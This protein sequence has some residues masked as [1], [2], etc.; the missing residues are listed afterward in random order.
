MRPPARAL[1]VLLLLALLL[2][3]PV[4]PP[5]AASHPGEAQL[6][7]E[8][9]LP[10]GDLVEAA[11]ALDR[12]DEAGASD[13]VEAA[14]TAW[15]DRFR[16]HSAEGVPTG[17]ADAA[18]DAMADES[19]PV[20]F[21]TLLVRFE[22][23]LFEVAV[24][25]VE[26]A[27]E[28]GEADGDGGG[29]VDHAAAHAW[30]LAARRLVDQPGRMLPFDAPLS[31][32]AAERDPSPTAVAAA[33]DAAAA[34]RLLE[35]V[36]A[37]DDLHALGEDPAWSLHVDRGRPWWNA[38]RPRAE[39]VLPPAAFGALDRNMS[40]LEAVIEA[41]SRDAPPPL[42]GVRG[43]LTS[44][45]YHRS[46]ERLDE[47][48]AGVEAGL[49]GLHRALHRDP[50]RADARW[51]AF[52]A[53]YARHRS[54]LVLVGEGQAPTLDAAVLDVNASRPDGTSA[55]DDAVAHAARTLRDAALLEYGLVLKVEV[56]AV[57]TDRVH[58]YQVTLLRPPLE[59]LRSYAVDLA[60]DPAVV[61]VRDVEPL[62]FDANFSAVIDADVG[63]AAFG[64]A[65]PGPD[66]FRTGAVVAH[67]RLTAV[68]QP[69]QE[70]ALNATATTFTT[71]RGEAAEVF[72]VRDGRA[73]VADIRVDGD[74]DG[75]DDGGPGGPLP[76]PGAAWS[77]VAL[78]LA[79]LVA[80]HRRRERRS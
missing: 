65:E 58:R 52:L 75:G 26:A 22:A 31:A 34:F 12:G 53:D 46:I 59:G 41:M 71:T 47:V 32:L 20:R 50:L 77:L 74:G 42:P 45:A 15:Q 19:D 68:G 23:A 30:L 8:G 3:A 72:F 29:T 7:G 16:A 27:L 73:T 37:A 57:R 36:Q 1:P 54:F 44:M 24:G 13:H 70:T 49:F 35:E 61:E 9:P 78:V 11:R 43:P 56:G 28:A 18:L 62:R 48:G 79:L 4:P 55:V 33:L 69:G 2:L 17:A 67:L 80:G 64:G 14:R 51:D 40:K 10:V 5:A 25:N 6:A 63:Q 38:T 76:L 66:G 21:R 39:A 60:W